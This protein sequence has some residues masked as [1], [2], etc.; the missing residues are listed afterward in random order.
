MEVTAY[1]QVV[2]DAGTGTIQE[3][4][5]PE[6]VLGRNSDCDISIEDFG[7]SRRHAQILH[8]QDDFF[9]EDLHSTNGTFLNDQPIHNRQKIANGDRIRI[10]DIT[11]E[12]HHDVS[13]QAPP[14][15][16]PAPP[17]ISVHDE[18]GDEKLAVVSQCEVCPHPSPLLEREENEK[19]SSTSLHAELKVP[20][21]Q[22]GIEN[23]RE[24]ADRLQQGILPSH[25]PELPG[26][27]FYQYY[28][29][30]AHTGGDFYDYVLMYDGRLMVFMADITGHGATAAMLIARLALE[31]RSSLLI[32]STPSDMMRNLNHA[33]FRYLPQDHFIKMVVVEL[34]PATGEATLVN[35]GH[36]QPLLHSQDGKV[37]QLGGDQAGL[38][39]GVAD[40][41]DYTEIPCVLPC[42][43]TLILYTDGMGQ[44][45]SPSGQV[46]G[47]ERIR[48][49]VAAVH[50][51]SVEIG[52]R[53]VADV[54]QFIGGAEQRD[55]LCVVCLG[56]E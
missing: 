12:F 52:E 8:I 28:C 42:D 26:Y 48:S 41:A 15:A 56:R 29:P 17:K 27:R 55:D 6:L 9:L 30:A 40:D 43:G 16:R 38:P 45:T 51:S 2:N 7:I 25:A 35:A 39:L 36:Q 50:G 22:Q 44:A 23:E 4:N 54:R 18:T 49:Q 33:L 19:Q 21:R 34:V 13:L 32:S 11:F 46:Y 24:F 3:M 47:H 20:L 37:R 1:L 10:S 53:L 31:I 14:A 5:K